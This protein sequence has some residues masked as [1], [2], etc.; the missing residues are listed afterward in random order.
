MNKYL[1]QIARAIL[2][3]KPNGISKVKFAKTI[4]FTHKGLI[5]GGKAEKDEL[6]YIRM[7]LGPVPV[8]FMKLINEENI[9]VSRSNVGLTYDQEIFHL[10]AEGQKKPIN[11]SLPI[12]EIK[13]ILE[14]LGD[15]PTS[16]LVEDSHKEPS[17]MKHKNGDEYCISDEDLAR[18]LPKNKFINRLLGKEISQATD[19]QRLQARLLDGMIDDI[20][21][22]TT[23]LEYPEE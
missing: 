6:Y 23:A 4:Y 15:I 12:K 20:V 5:K 19:D 9:E 1:K 8:D 7:P 13:S 10:S 14:D 2:F 22:E 11:S 17:W 16:R 21:N 3:N 18:P